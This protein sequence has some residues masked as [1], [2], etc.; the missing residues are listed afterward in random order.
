MA[1]FIKDEF[2]NES[3]EAF[4]GVSVTGDATITERQQEDIYMTIT[5]GDWGGI[6]QQ[7]LQDAFLDI[8][9]RIEIPG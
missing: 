1:I 6:N 4:W 5:D 8:W 2:N 9:T 3:I 7:G